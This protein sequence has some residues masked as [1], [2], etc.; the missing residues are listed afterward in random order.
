MSASSSCL[1]SSISASSPA[2]TLRLSFDLAFLPLNAAQLG[3][4]ESSERTRSPGASSSRRAR[5]PRTPWPRPR[6]ASGSLASSASYARRSLPVVEWVNAKSL[7]SGE[8]QRTW[9]SRRAR[10]TALQR[11]RGQIEASRSVGLRRR[12]QRWPRSRLTR[13][14]RRFQRSRAA[15][16]SPSVEPLDPWNCES[17]GWK[18]VS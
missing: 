3:M 11:K 10:R 14:R 1:I 16:S 7:V 5:R 2:S 4:L 17:R 9:A 18:S 15:A 6:P 13:A 8:W 12:G